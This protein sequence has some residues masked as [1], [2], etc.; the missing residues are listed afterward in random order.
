MLSRVF[1]AKH[2]HELV[3]LGQKPHLDTV[4][5][6]PNCKRMWRFTSRLSG[7]PAV[8]VCSSQ[9]EGIIPPHPVFAAGTY[10]FASHVMLNHMDGRCQHDA[11]RRCKRIVPVYGMFARRHAVQCVPAMR[12]G[13][14]TL[15]TTCVFFAGRM[16][17]YVRLRG[18]EAR[19][20]V[21]RGVFRL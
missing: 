11:T 7:V 18:H 2:S 5:V 4:N 13:E 21:Y 6:Q 16:E 15:Y 8:L 12:P 10:D 14:Q 20:C 3:Y 9:Q 17:C 19:E 1:M